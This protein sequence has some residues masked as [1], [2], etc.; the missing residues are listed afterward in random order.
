MRKRG[1]PPYCRNKR[2]EPRERGE[3]GKV[4]R[5][6]RGERAQKKQSGDSLGNAGGKGTKGGKEEK[7]ERRETIWESCHEGGGGEIKKNIPSYSPEKQPFQ[8]QRQP[9]FIFSGAQ[10]GGRE[11]ENPSWMETT[12][13]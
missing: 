6:E 2:G 13:A 9:E 8:S 5:K 1:N 7:E 3:L 12:K 10:M 4:P 11:K